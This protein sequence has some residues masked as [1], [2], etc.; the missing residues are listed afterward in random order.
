MTFKK[1]KNAMLPFNEKKKPKK[2]WWLRA[3]SGPPEIDLTPTRDSIS[4]PERHFTSM[5]SSARTSVSTGPIP[6][7][8]P[9]SDSDGESLLRVDTVESSVASFFTE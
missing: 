5:Q 7:S 4:S 1:N 9:F 8:R 3:L 6:Q 2:S